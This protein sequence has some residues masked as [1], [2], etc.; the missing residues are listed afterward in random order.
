M[1]AT[2][3]T[4]FRDSFIWSK[5]WPGNL[6][7]AER[8]ETYDR[9]KKFAV[10]YGCFIG[11]GILTITVGDYFVSPLSMSGR[12]T[13]IWIICPLLAALLAWATFAFWKCIPFKL[14]SKWNRASF[15]AFIV[16]V[17]AVAIYV[18]SIID[19]LKK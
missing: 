11:A 8:H 13:A 1:K 10:A 5:N 9:I 6:P 2:F 15:F 17:F 4:K 19:P 16:A 14:M 12:R 7:A 3:G 18:M